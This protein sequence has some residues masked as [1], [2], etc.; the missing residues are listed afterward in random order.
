MF[1]YCLNNPVMMCDIGGF[2]AVINTRTMDGYVEPGS[3]YYSDGQEKRDV[4]DEILS[5]LTKAAR[6]ARRMRTKANRYSI[7][8]TNR[9]E[10]VADIYTE[11]LSLVDHGAPWDIKRQKVW[12]STIGTTH[13][14]D[15]TEVIFAGNI[16]TPES[17]GNFTYGYLGYAYGIPL[18]ILIGGSY[19]AAG[20]PLVRPH[21]NNSGLSNEIIDWSYIKMGYEYAQ[22]GYLEG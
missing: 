6:R 14:G 19:Y 1:A 3:R 13:P 15:G 21:G 12:E 4:T 17:L 8:D 20:F 5:V 22:N 9:W 10:T 11:F 18:E 7:S 16:M 2:R